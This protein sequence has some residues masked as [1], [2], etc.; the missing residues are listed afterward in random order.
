M[1]RLTVYSIIVTILV[2]ICS[3]SQA[4]E[5][6][7]YLAE[8]ADIN[9]VVV[10]HN[11]EAYRMQ[12]GI[13]CRSLWKYRQELITIQSPGDS[14]LGEGAKIILPDSEQ[15]CNIHHPKFIG[16]WEKTIFIE[17]PEPTSQETNKPAQ[18]KE[19]KELQPFTY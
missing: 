17:I 1:R 13:G 12:N 11:G 16:P 5:E 15:S 18:N 3:F 7:V 19:S 8:I 4:G 9:L 10:R 2:S 14:F 6:E